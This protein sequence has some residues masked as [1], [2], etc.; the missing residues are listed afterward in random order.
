MDTDI[1]RDQRLGAGAGLTSNR[2]KQR[3]RYTCIE[4]THAS[5]A[6]YWCASKIANIVNV[7]NNRIKHFIQRDFMF[8]NAD[9]CVFAA[10]I[11]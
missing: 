3:L 6:G 2:V 5:V 8:V 1:I 10:H 11:S 4:K 9:V 7:Q